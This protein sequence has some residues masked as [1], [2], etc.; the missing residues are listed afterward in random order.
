MAQIGQKVSY[1][2]IKM[3]SKYSTLN[4]D[5]LSVYSLQRP[6]CDADTS[7]DTIAKDEPLQASPSKRPATGLSSFSFRPSPLQSATKGFTL[8]QSSLKPPLMSVAV[9]TP[10][11]T[12]NA[13]SIP[14][15]SST[16]VEK[17]N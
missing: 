14:E 17:C 13:E 2:F 15:Q 4:N 16:E 7:T 6:N 1:N 3:H 12:A 5:S 11:K 8:R 10:S 9:P